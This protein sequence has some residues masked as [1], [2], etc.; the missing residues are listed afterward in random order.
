MKPFAEDDLARSATV[1]VS[2][3]EPPDSNS[4]GMIEQLQCLVLA[5]AGATQARRRADPA[6]IA[7]SK[8]DPLDVTRTQNVA[9]SIMM[10]GA[11]SNR[12]NLAVHE[13]S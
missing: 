4:T 8:E 13:P 2:R 11:F 3:V 5:V 12:L 10:V 7:A 6:E 1:G 9:I